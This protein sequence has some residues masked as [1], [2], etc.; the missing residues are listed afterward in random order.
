[1][2]KSSN[3]VINT[4]EVKENIQ[5][6]GNELDWLSVDDFSYG[7][8]TAP[9]F[10]S[11]EEEGGLDHV[12]LAHEEVFGNTYF[13]TTNK[14]GE[15]I[16]GF[17][18][19]P[20]DIKNV[21]Y[22]IISK[23]LEGFIQL[24]KNDDSTEEV[25]KE[26]Q[27]FNERLLSDAGHFKDVIIMPSSEDLTADAMMQLYGFML[28]EGVDIEVELLKAA[29]QYDKLKNN[30]IEA[31]KRV[32]RETKTVKQETPKAEKKE[33]TSIPKKEEVPRTTPSASGGPFPDDEV[34]QPQAKLQQQKTNKT[35]NTTAN[36]TQ[37]KTEEVFTA[38]LVS[39]EG[40]LGDHEYRKFIEERNQKINRACALKWEGISFDSSSEVQS[41]MAE[42]LS[43]CEGML[44]VGPS[45]TGKTY[46]AER[47]SSANNIIFD[48]LSLSVN[49]DETEIMGK[50]SMREDKFSGEIGMGYDLGK[51]AEMALAAQKRARMIADGM[52]APLSMFMFD[53]VGRMADISPLV[54]ALSVNH[55]DEYS[56]SVDKA[57]F[58]A[59]IETVNN[60][61]VWFHVIDEIDKET[62]K[63]YNVSEDGKIYFNEDPKAQFLSYSGDSS[64]AGQ[65][66]NRGDL[67][68][69][70]KANWTKVHTQALNTIVKTAEPK[71]SIHL[72]FYA[73]NIVMT[74]NRG[75]KHNLNSKIDAAFASRFS[76]I[77]VGSTRISTMVKSCIE[78][79]MYLK[80]WTEPERKTIEHKLMVYF[81]NINHIIT[82]DDQHDEVEPIDFRDVMRIVRA[83]PRTNP[84]SKT[85]ENIYTVLEARVTDFVPFNS[86]ED[87]TLEEVLDHSMTHVANSALNI[88]KGDNLPD[89][90]AREEK[91]L[92][93]AAKQR[94]QNMARQQARS[95]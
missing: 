55:L 29:E 18:E 84:L 22:G 94:S 72:P 5:S 90:E 53:E 4:N 78:K 82:K 26:I 30:I 40:R 17:M 33:E 9:R 3:V 21:S 91:I 44:L 59:K 35:Q 56:I 16:A 60:G 70:S 95:M 43:S 14:D 88:I 28:K 41:K 61:E 85:G 50:T 19:H 24:A 10:A 37:P 58:L 77:I 42:R 68:T 31:A 12:F 51:F 86:E 75:E 13:F 65:R 71:M 48:K 80:D 81:D 6:L 69:I 62:Q 92:K 54:S 76:P 20:E 23:N 15:I 93:E 45:G 11:G 57:L 38:D 52:D 25:N 73:M 66:A 64:I 74:T 8:V 34:V 79:S 87:M 67:L 47:L 39:Q 27:K 63:G 89:I 32:S 7:V 83:L 36:A 46:E 49:V 1:M 2:L